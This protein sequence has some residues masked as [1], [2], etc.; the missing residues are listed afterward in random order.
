VEIDMARKQWRRGDRVVHAGRP[1]W[2]I[3]EVTAAEGIIQ[4]SVACQRLT[5]RFARAGLKTISTAFADLQEASGLPVIA[6]SNGHQEEW[7]PLAAES[8]VEVFSR[9]PEPATDPFR[10]LEDRLKSSFDLF[11]FTGSGASLLDWAVMQTRMPDPLSRF[12]RHELEEHFTRF[13]AA[14]VAHVRRLAADAEKK[15]PGVLP[16]AL[17][18]APPAAQQVLRRADARR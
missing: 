4:D 3:G 1:E 9:L 7:P 16:R 14:L 2:G 10:T 17:A 6:E 5:I 11:R 18:S 13:R 15:D 12:S 8:A